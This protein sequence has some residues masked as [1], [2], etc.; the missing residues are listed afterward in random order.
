VERLI[1]FSKAPRLHDV[2]TRL[3]ARLNPEQALRLHEAMLHDQLRFLA[4]FLATGW[5]VEVCLDQPFESAGLPL[6]LQGEGDL[7][8][9]M[10]RALDRAFDAGASAA[11]ILGADAPTLPRTL[12]EEALA[13]V[14]HGADAAIVPALDGG[15]VLVAAGRSVPE[16]FRDVPW[17]TPAVVAATRRQAAENGLTLAETAPW[18]DVDVEGDLPR[19]AAELTADPSRAPETAA[20]VLGLGLY[21][22]Q[23]PML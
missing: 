21:G 10:G 9:R 5:E 2:K 17:G 6:T 8:A 13:F 16:L 14:R 23:N 18:P 22:P 12:V 15:Y 3:A 7:G 1:L 11:A 4:Q 20:I 19:L